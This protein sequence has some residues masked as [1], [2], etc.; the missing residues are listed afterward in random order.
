LRK[1]KISRLNSKKKEKKPTGLKKMPPKR[2]APKRGG[3]LPLMMIPGGLMGLA[4]M[5]KATG[6]ARPRRRR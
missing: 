6:G 3:F 5:M 2:K 1:N 4:A